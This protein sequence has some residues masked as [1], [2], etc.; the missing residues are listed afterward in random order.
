VIFALYCVSLPNYEVI[1]STI[2]QEL[3]ST[4]KGELA[5]DAI[6]RALFS[7]DAS[8]YQIEPDGVVWPFDAD[9]VAQ[10][11]RLA[12][13]YRMAVLPRGGGTSLAG[14]T[15]G[16]AIQLDF[17]KHMRHVLELNVAERYAWVEPGIVLDEFNASI[18]AHGLKF[19]PD[20]SPANRATI[21]GM[22]GNNS[23]GMYS[24]KYGKTSDHVLE[25]RVMLADG[26][27]VTL[28]PL[29]PDA[30]REKLLLDSLE[31][32]AYRTIKRLA[33][34]HAQEIEQRF[35]KLLRRVGGYNLDAFINPDQ[36][37]DLSRLII[38]SE[39]TLAII[40]AAKIKLV[41][42]P[43]HTAIAVLEYESLEQAL[44]CVT[45]CLEC[46]PAAVELMDE[47]LLDLTRASREYSQH[48]AQFVQGTPGGLL[49]VEFFGETEQ[50]VLD[51]LDRLEERL[52]QGS[53]FAFRMTRALSAKQKNAVLQVRK[54][55]M[56]LL[57]SISPDR[58]PETVIEDSAVHPSRL[59]EYI[60]R[61]RQIC[62]Q[63]NTPVAIYGHASVGLIHARPL[64]NLKDAEDLR[65]M[66]SIAEAVKDLVLEFGGSL[67]G[68]HGDGLVRSEFNPDMFGPTL[69]EAFREVK[70]TFDPHR[71][72]NSGKIVD[73]QPLDINLRY[74]ANY[75]TNTPNPTHFQFR[76]TGGFAG[77][78]ELCNGNAQCR[79]TSSGTMCPSYM[80]T[81]DE[82]HSTRGRANALRMVFSGALPAS[83]LSSQR[84]HEVMELCVE[85]KACSSECPSRVNMTRIKS[86]WL[87]SV[88]REHGV[89]LRARMFG[90]IRTI[91]QIGSALAPI[92]NTLAQLPISGQIAERTLNISSKRRLPRF[93]RQSFTRWFKQQPSQTGSAGTVV[94]FPD[95]FTLYNEPHVGQAAVKVL[96]AAGYHVILP[97]QLVCCGRSHLSKGLLPEAKRLA[98]QQVAA[99]MPYV[100]AGL[101]IIG[102]EPSCTLTF[103]DEYP[104]LLSDPQAEQLAQQVVLLDEFL[105]RER[106]F[107]RLEFANT[108]A[109]RRYVVHGHCHQ[110]AL[111]GMNATRSLLER[112]PNCTVHE[113]DSG[114]CGM[115]GSFGYEAEHYAISQQIGER[116]LLPA[117]RAL[118]DNE[119]LVASGTSCRHQIA[120]GS[121]HHAKHLAEVLAEALGN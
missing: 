114:C 99:L 52:Q 94:L 62:A 42:R 26:S 79:K 46:E 9:D 98:A 67:S 115:A 34:D 73:A 23:S 18:A 48:L 3:Q 70:Q 75:Q 59:S 77:A 85:C 40:L 31:G 50:D 110:K 6:S 54:A 5:H 13:Q 68:E 10:V 81:R 47:M 89:P 24:L 11:L 69:Y 51:A 21:G 2:W 91:N 87:A 4:I 111:V 82:Q 58:K 38:G 119:Q 92:A 57:Q 71:V 30:L 116:V 15:V 101:P 29:Q 39:G 49:Q 41:E 43:K 97:K 103:R 55:S 64:L 27:V 45:L 22:I 113:L 63:H 72:L 74:G 20:V 83:E 65:T 17:A 8:I 25:L 105:M 78:V 88:Y 112:I 19:A 117:A 84:M 12:R 90:N 106:A 14:Q 104:D 16:K 33:R 44:D 60:R 32:R 76:D 61:L 36:P 1:V 35:P 102:L 100:Q 109:V 80:V 86:E 107:E 56:P 53:P 7:T 93:A 108:Q 120:D 95:T 37:F 28:G 66:R 96:Q 121:Q 118:Q